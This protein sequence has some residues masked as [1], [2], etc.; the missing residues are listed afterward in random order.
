[1]L[2]LWHAARCL[3]SRP[4]GAGRIHSPC[5]LPRP[6]FVGRFA[7]MKLAGRAAPRPDQDLNRKSCLVIP[8]CEVL[9]RKDREQGLPYESDADKTDEEIVVGLMEI[10]AISLTDVLDD[11]PSY[12]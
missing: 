12:E 3:A 10:T 6:L 1:M 8:M 9:E 7:E 11:E 4:V 2:F 5:G